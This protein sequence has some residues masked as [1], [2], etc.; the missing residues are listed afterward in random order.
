VFLPSASYTSHTIQQIPSDRFGEESHQRRRPINSSP[1]VPQPSS[2][3]GL[4]NSDLPN[5]PI[6]L[7]LEPDGGWSSSFA[8]AG[9]TVRRAP[10]QPLCP[11]SGLS[12][13]IVL[14]PW[15]LMRRRTD[16]QMCCSNSCNGTPLWDAATGRCRV[17]AFSVSLSFRR[18]IRCLIVWYFTC[19]NSRIRCVSGA[20]QSSGESGITPRTHELVSSNI[21]M[22]L[23]P[24]RPLVSCCRARIF[25]MASAVQGQGWR[26][27][28]RRCPDQ[29]AKRAAI[30]GT[31]T[32]ALSVL[33]N[34]TDTVDSTPCIRRTDSPTRRVIGGRD[35]GS[36]YQLG[37]HK[38]LATLKCTGTIPNTE[39]MRG[40]T[41]SVN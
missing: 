18:I 41:L 35:Y 33:F 8:N 2:S 20:L 38:L 17:P 28:W 10:L 3:L 39:T 32:R 11:L 36:K 12:R 31:H 15:S 23:G 29:I 1:A 40:T 34:D 37:L 27:R 21:Q 30:H 13:T 7:T 5:N 25:D 6:S 9:R 24:T 14:T 26:I 4:P 16:S 19:E 22:L